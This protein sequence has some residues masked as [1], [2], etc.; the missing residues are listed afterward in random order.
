M[1]EE[2]WLGCGENSGP[3]RKQEASWSSGPG[4]SY[5]QTH[6]LSVSIAVD[7]CVC[8]CVLL[9]L[10]LR[11]SSTVSSWRR[12]RGAKHGEGL[13]CATCNRSGNDC[14]GRRG[15]HRRSSVLQLCLPPQDGA[16]GEARTGLLLLL[17]S[18]VHPWDSETTLITPLSRTVGAAGQC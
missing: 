8:L 5:S 2:R 14:K 13:I 18:S 17:L 9:V 7:A 10:S 12:A 3:P 11:A 15:T 4:L 16:P 6:P 1:L